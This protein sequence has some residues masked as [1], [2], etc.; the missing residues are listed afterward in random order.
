MSSS[1]PRASPAPIEKPPPVQFNQPQYPQYQQMP[2]PQPMYQ[3]YPPNNDVPRPSK[4]WNVSKI[5][6]GS[7]LVVFD[8]ILIAMGAAMIP[9]TYAYWSWQFMYIIVACVV[10]FS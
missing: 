10:W 3:P 5:I 2:M 4:T 8:I 7:L 9:M 1:P 6:L